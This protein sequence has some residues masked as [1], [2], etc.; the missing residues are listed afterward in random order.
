MMTHLSWMSNSK[1][2]HSVWKFASNLFMSTEKWSYKY[3]LVFFSII[4]KFLSEYLYQNRKHSFIFFSVHRNVFSQ[5]TKMHAKMALFAITSVDTELHP[6][7]ALVSAETAQTTH[8]Y[9]VVV[10]NGCMPK[11]R[12]GCSAGQSHGHDGMGQG[13]AALWAGLGYMW[14]LGHRLD[15]P[16]STLDGY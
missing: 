14:P 16:E 4:L 7:L 11:A 12:M 1:S 6:S 15:M 9:L 8:Q 13:V 3:K 10:S 2:I 5:R